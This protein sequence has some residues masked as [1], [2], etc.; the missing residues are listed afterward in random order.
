MCP[1]GCIGQ[2][3]KIYRA[4]LGK[5]K[6]SLP[7]RGKR[8]NFNH[9]SLQRVKKKYATRGLFLVVILVGILSI[10]S[11]FT[12][13]LG[14]HIS[15]QT[16]GADEVFS[17]QA[18]YSA[19]MYF[20]EFA[21]QS[22]SANESSERN[23]PVQE[24]VNRS[25]ILQQSDGGTRL[26]PGDIVPGE[27]SR[28]GSMLTPDLV[29]EELR[30]LDPVQIADYPL[31]LLSSDDILATLDLL[32]DTDLQKIFGNIKPENLQAIFAKIPGSMHELILDRLDPGTES[33]VRN[34]IGTG[35]NPS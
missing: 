28:D 33:Y 26:D 35:A 27:I 12:I 25:L 21:L 17:D 11:S 10:F 1:L 6:C 30:S 3:D 19:W 14:I 9:S 22:G 2:Y 24:A 34:S 13:W 29:A 5:I 32:S 8:L 15:L 31:H 16:A 7:I 20:R 18:F 23:E 4:Y